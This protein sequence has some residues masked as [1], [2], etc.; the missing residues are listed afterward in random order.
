[1]VF[2]P[3][4]RA[5]IFAGESG[6]DYDALFGFSNRPGK[7]FASRKLTDMTVDE[8][9]NFSMPKGEYGQWVKGQ[10]GRVATPMGAYQIVGTTLRGAKKGLG[11]SGTER[12]DQATQDRL[13]QYILQQQGTGAWEG[14]RGPRDP[15]KF[16]GKA[17]SVRGSRDAM[18]AATR[19][20]F[21]PS[22]GN[23]NVS[24]SP[25]ATSGAAAL[26]GP[27]PSVN[28]TQ[29][30][31]GIERS[32]RE[33]TVSESLAKAYDDQMAAQKDAAWA[34]IREAMAPKPVVQPFTGWSSRYGLV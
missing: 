30:E 24:S 15:G 33:P 32:S 28:Q 22:G 4:I 10:I 9:I 5:G 21:K 12:M 1:M 25:V 26:F 8:A 18:E 19:A 14:Y 17:S 6:G 16:Q 27:S 3:R 11:L 29:G 23:P 7:R 20:S 13:G 34:W 31:T 2:D